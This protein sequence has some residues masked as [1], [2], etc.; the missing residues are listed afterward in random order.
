MHALPD[1]GFPAFGNERWLSQAE[2]DLALLQ[3]LRPIDAERLAGFDALLRRR[4]P[5]PARAAFCHGDLVASQFLVAGADWSLTDFDLCHAGDPL[6]D[7]AI[8][9]ASLSYDVPA[10]HGDHAAAL[11]GIDGR[12][13]TQA[14]LDGYRGAGGADLTP[15]PWHRV[16]A[17]LYYLALMLKK[18]RVEEVA[19]KTLLD[20]TC[21]QANALDARDH[22][23]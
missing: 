21:R 7:V 6:R 12:G 9:L 8:F 22:A 5:V 19:F 2:N 11:A 15:L 14:Y 13:L 20:E 1:A 23:R 3:C 10:F 16:C 4:L 17:G 18:D